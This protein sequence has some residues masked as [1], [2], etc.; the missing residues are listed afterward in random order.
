MYRVSLLKLPPH[1]IK[2]TP[3]ESTCYVLMPHVVFSLQSKHFKT[4]NFNLRHRFMLN[5]IDQRAV[6]LPTL[7]QKHALISNSNANFTLY[8]FKL[9]QFCTY[10]IL[11]DLDN[12][13]TFLPV[14]D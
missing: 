1:I 10:D 14:F 11:S 13:L 6:N 7:T 3:Q 5:L 12:C 9:R 8:A 4:R 2:Y